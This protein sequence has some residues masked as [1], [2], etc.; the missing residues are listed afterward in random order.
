M[1][2]TFFNKIEYRKMSLH[3]VL[4]VVQFVNRKIGCGDKL[5]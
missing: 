3:V 1:P 2:P 4:Y 5:L